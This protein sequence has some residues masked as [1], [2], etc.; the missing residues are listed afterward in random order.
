[1]NNYQHLD[2]EDR[3]IIQSLIK[4]E[5]SCK[6]IAEAL[7][8]T[9]STIRREIKNN[10]YRT[11]PNRFNNY[12]PKTCSCAQRFPYVCNNCPKRNKMK[13][14]KYFYEAQKAQKKYE[15]NRSFSRIGTHV[16]NDDI[17][18]INA[19]IIDGLG[20]NQPLNHILVANEL[21]ISL[22]TAYRWINDGVLTSKIIDLQ[23]AVRYRIRPKEISRSSN[24]ANRVGRSYQDYLIHIT[25]NPEI[26][27]IEMDIVEG[28]MTDKKCILTFA[29]IK[30][31][32]LFSVLLALQNNENVV[33]AINQLELTLGFDVFIKFFGVILTDNGSEFNDASSIEISPYTGKRRTRLFYCD[34][35]RSDQKG[36]VERKHVDM[37]LII[38]KKKSIEH[39]TKEKVDLMNSHINAILRPTLNNISTYSFASFLHGSEI[40]ALLG[41]VYID[42]KDMVLKPSLIN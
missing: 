37:R 34:P 31:N 22:S 15:S 16:S 33:D 32:L 38:P 20:N 11:N 25:K 29:C 17:E 35:N 30:S 36:T 42:P 4:L 19:T 18:K 14:Y 6:M 8:R 13:E 12:H 5:Y 28:L 27:M 7:G 24:T 39:L 40:I 1:M 10:R 26:N 2:I 23:K 21:P 9:Q 41:I 3:T